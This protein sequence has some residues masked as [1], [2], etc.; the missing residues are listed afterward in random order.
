MADDPIPLLRPLPEGDFRSRRAYLSDEVFLNSL[1]GGESPNDPVGPASWEGFFDLSTDVVLRTTDHQGSLVGDCWNLTLDWFTL[2]P[3]EPSVA[4]FMFEPALDA[5]DDFRAA[6][7]V[8]LHGWYRQGSVLLRTA[9]EVMT[10]A[11]AFYVSGR[12]D[13]FVKWREGERELNFPASLKVLRK[14]IGSYGV[15]GPG[16]VLDI[17]YG[18][19]SDAVHAKRDTNN[20]HIWAGNGPIW[21]PEGFSRFH[22]G[23]RDTVT[24][25]HL[26]M[27][28]GLPDY[29]MPENSRGLIEN[30]TGRWTDLGPEGVAYFLQQ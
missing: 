19:L 24:A 1:G 13:D 23:F 29:E 22:H 25:C 4:P 15:F 18:D 7:L 5:S 9:L 16:E 8:A 30:P 21:V 27:R 20:V 6:P 26:M 14:K 17:I 3:A 11:T 2:I 28:I 12:W 10:E